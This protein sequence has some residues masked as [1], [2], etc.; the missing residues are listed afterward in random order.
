MAGLPIGQNR[1]EAKTLPLDQD[2]MANGGYR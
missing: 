2:S 1:A